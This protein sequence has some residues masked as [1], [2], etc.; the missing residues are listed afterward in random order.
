MSDNK[1][2]GEFKGDASAEGE[3]EKREEGETVSA[4]S[5]NWLERREKVV[6]RAIEDEDMSKLKEVAALPGGY[7]SNEMRKRVW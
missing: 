3:K 1:S 2:T 6:Q 5:A 4:L 7:G